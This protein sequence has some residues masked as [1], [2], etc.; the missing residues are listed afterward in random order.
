MTDKEY[1]LYLPSDAS[2][3]HFPENKIGQYTVQLDSPIHLGEGG[4]AWEI[5]LLSVMYPS[6]WINLKRDAWIRVVKPPH[7][8]LN[9]YKIPRGIYIQGDLGK[10][11]LLKIYELHVDTGLAKLILGGLTKL[12]GDGTNY[13][14]VYPHVPLENV[15]DLTDGGTFQTITWKTKVDNLANGFH[16]MTVACPD[17]VEA[18]WWGETERRPYL[19]EFVPE[20]MNGT[21][22]MMR[23]S[24]PYVP[25]YCSLKKGLNQ[26]K[27][28]SI[29]VLDQ[30]KDLVE[31][32]G[33][34]VLCVLHLRRK[35]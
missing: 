3:Q 5:A 29:Q 4:M 34:K 14:N 33:G 23:E 13:E 17:V 2:P 11:K 35:K 28:I 6:R 16:L 9:E 18:D 22:V 8:I 1:Y 10:P 32:T 27:Q 15:A 25:R 24:T 26:L 30:D 12:R 31:F 7:R 19:Y 20:H 21:H